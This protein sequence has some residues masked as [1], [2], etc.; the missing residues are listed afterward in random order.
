MLRCVGTGVDMDIKKFCA[1]A[2]G[3]FPLSKP[4]VKDGWRYATDGRIAVR[5]P[6]DEPDSPWAFYDVGAVFAVR[7]LAKEK[8]M[9][10]I[11]A[12]DGKVENWER[13]ACVV[14]ENPPESCGRY[15]DCSYSE[16]EE[17]TN[18]VKGRTHANQC[19]GGK[20]WSGGQIALVNEQLPGALYTVT[21][22]GWM[23]FVCGNIEGMMAPMKH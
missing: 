11:P 7:P 17:C 23:R 14:A 5:E 1:D 13:P 18:T 19:F 2:D 6:T 15:G 8:A 10:V 16:D 3:R 22:N 21:R 4:W 9:A 20:S 12:H